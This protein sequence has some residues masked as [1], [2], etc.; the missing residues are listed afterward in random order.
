V[1]LEADIDRLYGVP[2]DEFVAERD[3]L[4]KRLNKEGD[5]EAG[6]RIKALRKPTV[7]AWALN[8]AV[9]RRR[10]ET[11]ALLA[12]GGRLQK[13]QDALLSG[14]DP[15]ELRKAIKEERTLT[16]GIAD[17]AEAIASEAGKSGP[18]LRDR[19]RATL[20]AAALD[21]E[22]RIELETGRF[23]REREAVGLG[24]FGAPG[25]SAPAPTRK[26]PARKRGRAAP[27]PA[28]TPKRTAAAQDGAGGARKSAPREDRARA[29]KSPSREDRAAA[30]KSAPREDRAAAREAAAREARLAEAESELSEARE[31][32]EAAV[33]EHSTALAA[34]ESARETL[35]DAEVTERDARRVM[36]EHEREVGKRER[37]ADRMRPNR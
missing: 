5:R 25:G 35:R 27:K 1:D 16:S 17:C 20:H 33:A 23:T 2:L 18:A 21:E 4:A 31:A 10:K 19:V 26:P 9:R 37:K 8:Q 3:Q 32:H 36:R 29:R 15:S 13:A 24:A 22:T 12:T 7:G 14:G 11:A 6:A 34:L 30:R 28:R